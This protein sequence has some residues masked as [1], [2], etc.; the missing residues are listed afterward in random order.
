MARMRPLTLT[1]LVLTFFM[2]SSFV[3]V[4][5]IGNWK[6]SRLPHPHGWHG[7]FRRRRRGKESVFYA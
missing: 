1:L 4:V 5:G 6:T 3:G 7:F 2:A